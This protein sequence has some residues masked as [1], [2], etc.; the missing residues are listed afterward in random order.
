M[1]YITKHE[2]LCT[3]ISI[4]LKNQEEI[5]VMDV[6][7][8]DVKKY[9]KETGNVCHSDE[10]EHCK[11]GVFEAQVRCVIELDGIFVEKP[12]KVT[13]QYKSIYKLSDSRHEYDCI[14]ETVSII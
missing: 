13:G 10:L 9:F 5:N 6:I 8:V 1:V 7:S 11:D 4:A 14:I 2:A 3:G 12:E